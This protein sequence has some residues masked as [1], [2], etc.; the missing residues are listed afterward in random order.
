MPPQVHGSLGV[1]ESVPWPHGPAGAFQQL[2]HEAR[3]QRAGRLRRLVRQA[4]LSSNVGRTLCGCA[5]SPQ[6]RVSNKSHCPAHAA[7]HLGC[8]DTPGFQNI[9]AEAKT[10]PALV[11]E[12]RF[13]WP[14]SRVLAPPAHLCLLWQL[15]GT[16]VSKTGKAR[17]MTEGQVMAPVLLAIPAGNGTRSATGWAR[18]AEDSG[19]LTGF[20][21]VT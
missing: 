17:Q 20:S 10:A 13:W 21:F 12:E 14:P 15:N 2:P 9:P 6:A 8:L 5:G 18:S 16:A 3:S 4:L 19:R 1:G 7:F 11:S